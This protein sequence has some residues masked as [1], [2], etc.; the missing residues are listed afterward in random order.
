MTRDVVHCLDHG[1]E[2]GWDTDPV[3]SL[4]FTY[5]AGKSVSVFE[6]LAAS[7]PTPEFA[8]AV[9]LTPGE[10]FGSLQV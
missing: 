1:C 4:I 5:G 8:A 6:D 3:E 2:M 9:N 7:L 10:V